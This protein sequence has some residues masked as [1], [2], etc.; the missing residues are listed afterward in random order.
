MFRVIYEDKN[1]LVID[2]PANL[3]VYPPKKGFSQK[4]LI[5]F[6]IA[7]YPQ[8]KKVG[9]DPQRPGLVHRL[10]RETSGLMLVA[11]NQNTFQY[12][13]SQFQNQKIEKRYLALVVGRV[14]EKK[15]IIA[16]TISFSKKHRLRKTAL[17]DEKAQ[18]AWTE[19]QVLEYF[20]DK[21]AHFYTL[22]EVKPKTG[23]TH[24]IRVHLKSI[25]YPLAGDKVYKFKKQP[26]PLGLS[27][28][29]LHAYYL[30][31]KLPQGEEKKFI[32]PLPKDLKNVLNQL[33]KIT[34]DF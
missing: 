27:R 30:K 29:F 32:S 13:V 17:L 4:T 14:K 5:D 23:R 18:Q 20:K 26:C 16:K 24:Q 19:Y 11:K 6:L 21:Q 33:E 7:K 31:L 28:Q 2:K 8:I 1:L 9:S 25:G 10:D 15:G 12:L 3:V 34:L 22:L